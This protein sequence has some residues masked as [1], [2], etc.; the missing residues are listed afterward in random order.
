MI[1]KIAKIIKSLFWEWSTGIASLLPNDFFS[2]KIRFYVYRLNGINLA[3]NALIYRNVLILGNVSI[4]KNSSISNNTCV[5]GAVAGVLIGND[6]MIAPGCCINAF[7]HG[8][9]LDA[10]PMI[11]Q[12]N[13]EAPVVIENDVWIA[14]NCTI[15]KGVTIGTGAIVA[16]NSVVTK[17]VAPY[18]IVGGVPAKLIG[19]RK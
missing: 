8:T 5:S 14:A 16:A 11:E 7:D 1:I 4:G 19:M 15:T 2:N 17:D 9:K 13:N 12:A 18:S 10:G 6:V 3:K